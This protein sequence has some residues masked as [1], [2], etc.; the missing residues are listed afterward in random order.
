MSK[1]FLDQEQIKEKVLA[2]EGELSD[3]DS[4]DFFVQF[5]LPKEFLA[6]LSEAVNAFPGNDTTEANP[7]DLGLSKLAE[8]YQAS[9]LTTQNKRKEVENVMG[10]IPTLKALSDYTKHSSGFCVLNSIAAEAIGLELSTLKYHASQ[11]AEFGYLLLIKHRRALDRI[12][13]TD[14]GFKAVAEKAEEVP[15]NRKRRKVI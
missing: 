10:C 5:R 2:K 12:E 11:L 1:S 13:I 8:Q 4:Q 15:Q 9:N 7:W 6:E 3:E 14:A